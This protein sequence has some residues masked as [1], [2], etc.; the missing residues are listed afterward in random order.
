MRMAL[1]QCHGVGA[2]VHALRTSE[3]AAPPQVLLG[4]RVPRVRIQLGPVGLLA[5]DDGRETEQQ[6][7]EKKEK[8]ERQDDVSVGTSNTMWTSAEMGETRTAEPAKAQSK[9][10][11]TPRCAIAAHEPSPYLGRGMVHRSSHTTTTTR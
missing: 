7:E 2:A 4:R 3:A 6:G 1:A 11:Q 5:R 10:K 8:E 9:A